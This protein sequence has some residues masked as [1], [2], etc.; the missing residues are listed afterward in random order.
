MHWLSAVV[1]AAVSN[2]DNLS[3]GLAFGLRGRRIMI[4]PNALIA[5]VTMAGT[6][7]AM[8]SGRAIGRLLPSGLAGALGAAIIV[9]IGV[10]TLVGWPPTRQPALSGE[11]TLSWHEA[12]VLGV[13]L[14]LNNIG[15]G[16]G[17]GIAG[18]SPVVTTLLAGLFSL[19]CVGGGSRL[20]RSLSRVLL[21]GLA[22]FVAG[23]VLVGL[24]VAM[25]TGAA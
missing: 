15:S 24:G 20:G 1:I 12:L 3:A 17:A 9:A 10:V 5:V 22:R 25:L 21:P 16:V 18:V 11:Q 8:T 7:G 19:L 4:A 2:L 23:V 13:A 6:A 14:S